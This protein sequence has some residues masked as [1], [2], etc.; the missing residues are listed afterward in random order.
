M[1]KNIFLLLAF[2]LT[3]YI[4]SRA[5]I[6]LPQLLSDGVVL[7]R[8]TKVNLW[9]WASPHETVDLFFQNKKF[10]ILLKSKESIY[11]LF[12]GKLIYIRNVNMHDM[13]NNETTLHK[14]G[15]D[16]LALTNVFY[17]HYKHL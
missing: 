6:K 9:G 17:K 14:T 13:F 1:K 10:Q 11:D 15:I 7:Q 5:Q 12:I 8:D 3:I 4:P 2:L 16:G